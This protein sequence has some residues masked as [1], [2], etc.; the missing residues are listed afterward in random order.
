MSSAAVESGRG[1]QGAPRPEL[2]RQGRRPSGSVLPAMARR[3]A[4]AV[5]TILGVS[6]LVFVALRVIPGNETT[7]TLG[8][9]SGLLSRAQRAAL[10]SYYGINQS[11]PHQ[12]LSWIGSI[13]A[14]NF[15]YSRAGQSVASMTAQ[16]L[17][18]TAEL[19]VLSSIVGFAV[20]VSLGVIAASRPGGV[21]DVGAQSFGLIGLAVPSFVLGSIVVTIVA[22]KTGYFPNGEQYASPTTNL[23]LNLQQM[24]FPCLILGLGFAAV[25]M[26]TTRTAMLEVARLDFVRTAKGK[27]LGGTRV[28]IKHMLRNALLPIVTITGIQFGYLLGGA[29]IV[30]QIFALPGLGQ[31]LL[32]AINDREYAVVQ[33]TA[34]VIAVAFV[35]VNCAVDLLY[36][37]IDPRVRSR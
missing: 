9:D 7:A 36:L 27:G 17:P 21:R 18:V 16:A 31:Q 8:V 11:L 32:T 22:T 3:L 33:S 2:T 5:G 30:E 1:T 25:V 24:L 28:L 14:G 4:A 35:L 34:L 6:V 23:S 15:G 37:R 12:F 20:G 29:I 10:D 13:L 26:R 19:A